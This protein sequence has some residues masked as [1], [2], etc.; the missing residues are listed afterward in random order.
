MPEDMAK[1]VFICVCH[2][3]RKRQTAELLGCMSFG[4]NNVRRKK[5]D[6]N[7]WFYLLAESVGRRKHLQVTSTSRHDS[8][9]VS[10]VS[11]PCASPWEPQQENQSL[12]VLLQ[13]SKL[14]YG[15]SLTG[16]CPPCV[17]RVD[18]GGPANIAGVRTGDFLIKVN[19]ENVSTATSE[20]SGRIIR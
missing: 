16:S 10:Q 5:K 11:D 6:V 15:F 13:R 8:S 17:A 4:I 7:G 1:R 9:R 19:G 14:G 20:Q 18:T 2:R 12:R 3:D